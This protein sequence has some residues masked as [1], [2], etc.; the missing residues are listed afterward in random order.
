MTMFVL[1]TGIAAFG[2]FCMI[3]PKYLL[4]RT[5]KSKGKEYNQK[6]VRFFRIFGAVLVG[7]YVLGFVIQAIINMKA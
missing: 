1:Y 4:E 3:N 6:D 5:K 2:L 7:L